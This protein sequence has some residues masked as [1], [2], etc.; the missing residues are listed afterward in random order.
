MAAWQV[1][2]EVSLTLVALNLCCVEKLSMAE[3]KVKTAVLVLAIPM[4]QFTRVIK[5]GLQVCNKDKFRQK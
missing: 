2:G 3:P 4:E 5:K 1:Q